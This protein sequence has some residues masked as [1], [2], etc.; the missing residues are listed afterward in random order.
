MPQVVALGF[1]DPKSDLLT[2]IAG[3]PFGLQGAT[4]VLRVVSAAGPDHWF[5]D[6]T[7]TLKLYD[8]HDA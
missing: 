2:V 8:G 7:G 3:L 1:A 6:A 5:D 4:N